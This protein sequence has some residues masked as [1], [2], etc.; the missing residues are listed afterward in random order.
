MQVQRVKRAVDKRAGQIA[1]AMA[2][3]LGNSL[4]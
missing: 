4:A 2:S 3:G 1:T